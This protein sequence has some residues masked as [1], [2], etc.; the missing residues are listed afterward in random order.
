MFIVYLTRIQLTDVVETLSDVTGKNVVISFLE[1]SA[2]EFLYILDI[3]DFG[4]EN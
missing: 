4:K 2:S 1:V 3:L